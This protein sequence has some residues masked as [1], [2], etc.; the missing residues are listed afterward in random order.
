VDLAGVPREIPHTDFHVIRLPR[1]SLAIWS[2]LALATG[3]LLGAIGHASGASAFHTLARLIE[4]LGAIWL[5]GLQLFLLPLIASQLLSAI[6]GAGAGAGREVGRLGLQA[7]LLFVAMLL[8]A[9][10]L[11]VFL[12]RLVVPLYKVDPA[13]VASLGG[14]TVVPAEAQ[15]AAASSAGGGTLRLP[16]NLVE[17]ARTNQILAIL[18]CA[19]LLG[20]AVTHLHEERRALLTSL[21][22]GFAEATMIV[23]RW[24]LMG[25]PVGVFALSYASGLQSGGGAAG[26][27]GAFLVIVC[28]LLALFTVLLYPLTAILGRTSVRTFARAAAPAQLVAVSTLSSI[29]ALPAL[30]QGAIDHLRLPPR[31]TGFLLPL[32]VS[33]FKVNRTIS[34]AAKLVFL[35]YVYGLP[36]GA[37]TLVVFMLTVVLMSFG[38][39]GVP[40]GGQ[41]FAMLPAYVAAGMPIEGIVLL[42]ATSFVT[43]ML[44]T[45]LNVTGDMSVAA[46]LSRSTRIAGAEPEVASALTIDAGNLLPGTNR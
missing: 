20:A 36:L 38:A 12:T 40:N 30:I 35:A 25:T 28:S 1:P 3:L 45:V 7:V 46:I 17:A 16:G 41:V 42:E 11:T 44:K 29:A 43:D 34:S 10:F 24:I 6:T 4:P 39:A 27:I 22:R 15:R 14:S 33:V 23:V 8:V 32:C 26:M 13:M 37:G 5:S 31:F 9:G 18:V 19:A 21:F 2:I